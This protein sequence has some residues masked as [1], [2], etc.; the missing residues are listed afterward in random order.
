MRYRSAIAPP[1]GILIDAGVANCGELPTH[2]VID[3]FDLSADHGY[4]VVVDAHPFVE[5]LVDE[6]S[7]Q[8]L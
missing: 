7:D 2:N 1:P 3:P 8:V 4:G 5:D 6:L